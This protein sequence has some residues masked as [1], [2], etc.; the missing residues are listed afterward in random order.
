L[1]RLESKLSTLKWRRLGIILFQDLPNLHDLSGWSIIAPAGQL[2]LSQAMGNGSF[3]Q[4]IS[5]PGKGKDS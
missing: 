3:P 4:F 2:T 1:L 5:L